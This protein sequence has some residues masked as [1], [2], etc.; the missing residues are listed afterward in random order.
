MRE[1]HIAARR[2]RGLGFVVTQPRSLK[3]A[4]FLPTLGGGGAE[5]VM[6][7]LAEAFDRHG[8][9]VD[10]VVA[11][12]VGELSQDVDD[13]LRLVDL[14]AGRVARSLLP[15]ARYLRTERPDCL[16]ASLG[17][18]NLAALAARWWAGS[19]TRI[20]VTEHLAV[21]AHAADFRD[22]AFRA[23][24]RWFYPRADAIVAVSH[25]V[26]DSFAIATGVSR[27]RIQVVYNPVLT[28]AYWQRVA[29]TCTH[30]W[31]AAG[32]PPVVLGVG[33]LN[34]Q[35]DFVTLIRAFARAR[36]RAPSRLLILGEGPE[37]ASLEREV[38]ANGLRLGEDVALPGF[39]GDPYPFMSSAGLFVL[40]SVREGLPTVLIEALAAGTRVVST[41][42]DS[43]PDEILAG[44]RY[45]K[46]VPVG[47]V[48]A[49]SDAMV[50][51]LASPRGSAP[52]AAWRPYTPETAVEGY[53]RAAGL[54]TS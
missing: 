30:P 23:V 20:V 48:D 2:I 32:Q 12:W 25:G 22:T 17:H 19:P 51:T 6:L 14:R 39:V 24:S 40:S 5:R 53:L 11:K 46:L 33:R 35:K 37:R 43:G 1:T 41:D 52:E 29:A 47:D 27:E 9:S 45:G 26:A 15:L 31:F 13:A 7:N 36:Q 38:A 34:P 16:I 44:G 4:V 50:A 42:C 28:P 54:V 49:L 8:L 3:V 18:A 10:I 21:D